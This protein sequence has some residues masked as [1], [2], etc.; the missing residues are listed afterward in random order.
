MYRTGTDYLAT[1]NLPD[2]S[3]G[4]RDAGIVVLFALSSYGM[5]YALMKLRTKA[6][7]KSS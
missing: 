6:A 4:W 2:Y 7:V 3:D 5:V 1:L